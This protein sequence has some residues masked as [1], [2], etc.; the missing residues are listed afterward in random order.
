MRTVKL[1]PEALRVEPFALGGTDER[2][3]TVQGHGGGGSLRNSCGGRTC[4]TLVCVCVVSQFATDCAAAC[5]V[6][7]V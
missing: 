3:G 1:D 6:A 2:A 5:V 4:D 7:A